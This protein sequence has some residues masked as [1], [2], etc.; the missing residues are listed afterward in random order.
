VVHWN[1]TVEPVSVDPGV[2]LDMLAGTG[3]PVAV[4]LTVT[5][6]EAV[7]LPMVLLAVNVYV[8]VC[9]G[10]TEMDVTSETSPTPLLILTEVAPE[11]LQDSA[12][13]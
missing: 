3:E 6:V 2:G 1:V 5:V 11:I 12:V 7:T 4:P 9:L 13:D 10:A 8:V